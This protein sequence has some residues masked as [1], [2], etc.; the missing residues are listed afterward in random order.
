VNG[1]PVSAAA[2]DQEVPAGHRPGACAGLRVVELAGSFAG[3]LASVFLADA[4]AEVVRV[5]PA[6]GSPDR[7][8]P[9]FYVAN[10]GK[11]AIFLDLKDPASLATVREL[12]RDSD[13]VIASWRPG[14]ASRLGLGYEALREVNSRLVYLTISGFGPMTEFD[15]IPGYEPVVSAVIGKMSMLDDISGKSPL[16]PEG[17]PVYTAANVCSYGAAQ[18]GAQGVLSALIELESSGRGQEVTTSLAQGGLAATLMRTD[19]PRTSGAGEVV[20]EERRKLRHRGVRLTFLTAE[21]ADGRFMQMCAR[22]EHHFKNWLDAMGIGD[23]LRE[24][25]YADLPL[26]F[27]SMEDAD[28]LEALIRERML[29][30]TLAEW[31]AIFLDTDVGGDP[32]LTSTEFLEHEQLLANDRI[33]T[34]ADPVRGPVRQVGPLGSFSDTPFRPSR[35]APPVDAAATGYQWTQRPPAAAAAAAAAPAAGGPLAGVTIVECATYV[36]GPWAGAVLAELGARVIKVEPPSG[37]GYRR[38]GNFVQMSHGKQSIAVNLKSAAGQQVLRELLGRADAVIHNFRPGVPE[39][40]G[41]G[42]DEVHAL[43]PGLVYVSASSYGTRGPQAKRAAFHSTPNALCGGGIL[44]GGRGNPPVDDSYPDP[45]GALA[46]AT[47]TLMGLHARR[48]SGLGQYIETSMIASAAYVH[49]DDLVQYEGRPPRRELDG[50]QRGEGALRRLYEVAGQWL[51]LYA[52]TGQ[53]WADLAH[54]LGRPDW[55]TDARFETAAARRAHDGELAAEITGALATAEAPAWTDR[56]QKVDVPCVAVRPDVGLPE[57]LIGRGLVTEAYHPDFDA[58]W[59]HF[60]LLEMSRSVVEVRPPCGLGEHTAAIMR[61]LGYDDAALRKLN[62]DK[63]V[64][65]HHG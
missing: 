38:S 16:T 14:V 4:G 32:F 12:V 43:F 40:L 49:V 65:V 47:A 25:R 7:G 35:S 61:E 53:H 30:R 59:K 1:S 15:A 55:L 26:G 52:A 5:E 19:M 42:Y 31:F 10:R 37:D 51:F 33:V 60:A 58:Y 13:V 57:F 39:R 48:R 24:P 34:I 62:D 46:V 63:L 2:R 17:I 50:G 11:S 44:Q 56:L 41:I 9:G 54:V 22:Q 36:A 20:A 45:V 27:K 21:C 18:L 64:T 29:T 28:E 23:V 8:Q 6:A 3:A